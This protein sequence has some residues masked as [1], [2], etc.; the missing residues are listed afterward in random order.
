MQ[1][2]R[3]VSIALKTPEWFKGRR[4]P[5]LAPRLDMLPLEEEE[6]RREYQAILDD[7]DPRQVYEDLGA[8]CGVVVLGAPRGLLPPAPGGGV[9]GTTS[10][11]GGAGAPP[12]LPP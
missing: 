11:G 2:Q 6:Y 7:L 1:D 4:Y 12:A 8:G 10:G 5:A 9:A 3:L